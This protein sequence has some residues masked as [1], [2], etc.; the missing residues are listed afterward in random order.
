MWLLVPIQG[1]IKD[2][3]GDYEK[4]PHQEGSSLTV[5]NIGYGLLRQA[6]L[7]K[8]LKDMETMSPP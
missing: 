1:K 3:F 6:E 2:F 5:S 4:Y 8:R 7:M